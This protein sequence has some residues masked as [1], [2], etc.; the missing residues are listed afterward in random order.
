MND[1]ERLERIAHAL[2][3]PISLEA[4]ILLIGMI[5]AADAD[6]L[7]EMPIGYEQSPPR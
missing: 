5:L 6:G 1:R 2:D 7:V 4:K 3:T